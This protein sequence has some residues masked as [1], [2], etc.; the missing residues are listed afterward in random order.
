L[1]NVSVTSTVAV[2]VEAEGEAPANTPVEEFRVTP[3]AEKL[4]A[5]IAQV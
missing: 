5:V 2:Q 3:H 1:L 4:P